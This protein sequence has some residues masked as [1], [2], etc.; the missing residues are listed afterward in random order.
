MT[1]KETLKVTEVFVPGGLPKYT[2]VSRSDRLLEDQIAETKNN[3]CKIATVTGATKSGK[4]VLVKTVLRQDNPVWI[5]GG[6]V[7]C[8]QDFL[9]ILADSLEVE[10]GSETVKQKSRS[11]ELSGG[12]EGE[13]GIPLVAK[14]KGNVAVKLAGS[15]G[16]QTTTALAR[17]ISRRVTNRLKD[18]RTPLV[19]DDFHYIPREVQGHITRFLKPLV[20]DAV[21]VIYLAI[22]HRRY[23]AVKVEREM[24]GRIQQVQVPPWEYRELAQIAQLGFP[25]INIS[26]HLATSSRLAGETHGSP[27]LM[28]EF[29]RQICF[30]SGLS[31]TSTMP[32]HINPQFN[33]ESIFTMVAKDLGKVI[34]EKLARGPRVRSDR[35]QRAL[36]TGKTADIYR[37][38]LLALANLRP[39]VETIDYERLRGSMRT[40]LADELPQVNEVARVLEHMAKIA[41]QD[42]S[43]VAVIDYEKDERRLHITDPF[44]A[45]F[46]RWGSELIYT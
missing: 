37:V 18:T 14:A 32:R 22:P 45:F 16:S 44:F 4:T 40:I 31:E 29:C 11:Q 27:H 2:Y 7:S 20:F 30:L 12:L 35:L 41:S 38:T 39:G 36:R 8:M 10:T 26:P 1:T 21:P 46:L 6:S 23:D 28:Q 24:N 3:L 25:L 13:G 33:Y 43:S 19:I 5:D 15:S 34:F 42:E 17:S 9:E